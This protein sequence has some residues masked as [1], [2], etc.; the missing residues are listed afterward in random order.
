MNTES[1]QF[2]IGLY[3]LEWWN[4]IAGWNTEM[5]FDPKVADKVIEG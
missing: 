4:C 2:T 5:T 1:I 3:G